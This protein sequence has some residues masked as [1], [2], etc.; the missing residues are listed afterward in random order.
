M[1]DHIFDPSTS[2]GA[3]LSPNPAEPAF[4][5]PPASPALEA[6]GQAAPASPQTGG[7]AGNFPSDTPDI[8]SSSA[9]LSDPREVVEYYPPLPKPQEVVET[10]VQPRRMPAGQSFPQR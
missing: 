1:N 4:T 7:A 9:S 3:P 10:Y 2:S 6:G 8:D 5:Q